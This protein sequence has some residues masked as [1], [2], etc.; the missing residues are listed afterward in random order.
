MMVVIVVKA[1]EP[2][3]KPN[4]GGKLQSVTVTVITLVLPS[5][6]HAAAGRSGNQTLGQASGS[7]RLRGGFVGM[8]SA[9]ERCQRGAVAAA[10]RVAA[11]H[12]R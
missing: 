2:G 3:S 8:A 1:W 5:H 11:A 6:P 12:A 7:E 4:Q 9:G 10:R